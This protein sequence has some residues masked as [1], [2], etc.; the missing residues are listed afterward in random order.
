VKPVR[1]ACG[2]VPQAFGQ[3]KCLTAVLSRHLGSLKAALPPFSMTTAWRLAIGILILASATRAHAQEFEVSMPVTLTAEAIQTHRLQTEDRTAVPYS[4]AFRALLYPT[5]KFSENW[6]VSATIQFSSTPFFYYDAFSADRAVEHQILQAFIGYKHNT[7]FGTF[8]VKA[9]QLTTA[10]GAFPPHYDDA[11]NPLIDQPLTYL[12]L[13]P[14]RVTRCSPDSDDEGLAPATLYGL[15]GVEIDASIHRLDLRLQVTNSSPTNPQSL[16]SDSQHVQWTAG[17]GYTFTNGFRI[18]M[19]GF[20]GPYLERGVIGPPTAN[21]LGVDAQWAR[22]RVSVTGEVAR[23]V[24]VSPVRSGYL[25]TKLT[26]TP[27]LFVAGRVSYLAPSLAATEGAAGYRIN[28]WQLLK[29]GYEWLKN[30]GVR[31]TRDNVLGV[32]FVTNIQHY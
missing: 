7:S 30:D 10:F 4:A 26:I 9:G 15:P 13:L 21:G 8:L 14:C 5:L 23:F 29:V 3:P 31:G 16:L 24:F 19:S 17:G 1:G 28:R 6:F 32:Q 12:P 18:G 20:R 22:G 25:E 27:R 11:D 2:G